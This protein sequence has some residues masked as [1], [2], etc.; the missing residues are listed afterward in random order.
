MKKM[1][2][3][4]L[5]AVW[6]AL[7]LVAPAW[8]AYGSFTPANQECLNCHGSSGTASTRWNF[9]PT[10]V[11]PTTACLQCHWNG[12]HVGA[13]QPRTDSAGN[14][15]G[16]FVRSDAYQLA[17]TD[18]TLFH[19]YHSG[20]NYWE[21]LLGS[22]SYCSSCHAAA[23]CDTC[24]ETPAGPTVRPHQNHAL[25]GRAAPT[26]TWAPGS[27]VMNFP[28]TATAGTLGCTVTE[29]HGNPNPVARVFSPGDVDTQDALTLEPVCTDCHSQ[30]VDHQAV[31][32]PSAQIGTDYAACAACHALNL[33]AEH[34]AN[35]GLQCATCH[36]PGAT[37]TN[38][39]DIGSVIAAFDGTDATKA[40][41]QACHGVNAGQH[42]AQHELVNPT[43]SDCTLCHSG[44]LVT[45]H[46]VNNPLGCDTC[47][48]AG[49][50][51][52]VKS[53]IATYGGANPLNPVCT[54]CH[55]SY[56][57]GATTKHTA[58]ESTGCT[59]CHL[60]LLPDEHARST[61]VSAPRSCA[62]CHPLPQSLIWTSRCAD[63]HKP[64]GLAPA[65]HL[66]IDTAHVSTQ[67][68]C[69]K[70]GCHASD[71]RTVHTAVG[72]NVCHSTTAVP[73]SADCTV[74]HGS[75]PH[76]MREPYKDSC[77]QCH[78]I[79]GPGAGLH[80]KHVIDKQVACVSCH[81]GVN[82]APPQ[83]PAC[84]TAACHEHSVD[85]VHA[86]K[87]HMAK[88]CTFCHK[89]GT[90]RHGPTPFKYGFTP[91]QFRQPCLSAGC[92][93][94]KAHMSNGE[95]LKCHGPDG[96]KDVH[97][98]QS[99][100]VV[101]RN[102][103]GKCHDL[104]QNTFTDCRLCHSF[105]PG[106]SSQYSTTTTTSST[107]TTTAPTTT[108]SST[109]TTTSSP[110]SSTTSTT[111]PA[112]TE[113]LVDKA[114]YL[115]SLNNNE[116]DNKA[117]R[118]SDVTLAMA[119]GGTAYSY[120]IERDRRMMSLQLNQSGGTVQKA[121]LKLYVNELKDG[122]SQTARIYLY[123]SDGNSLDGNLSFTLQRTG[124]VELDV[125]SLVRT[126]GGTWFKL[127]VTCSSEYFTISEA[128]FVL[129]R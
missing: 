9:S 41:C 127:R 31:H 49:A 46:T 10:P 20:D 2:F 73:T 21:N 88:P 55:A 72:C 7:L 38:G 65:A 22:S 99:K 5:A 102:A 43:V 86:K 42:T 3:V 74:C 100:H 95:C 128:G 40:G 24:H 47:H 29:C 8:A 129:T 80:D 121:V 116:P 44:N 77:D 59:T 33:A 109:T 84:A 6:V 89:S 96:V 52:T 103:C 26:L 107:T 108:T 93:D 92:H 91:E 110:T 106:W 119:D 30:A 61:S 94:Y 35:R 56:H 62:N 19:Q 83:P 112:V 78:S 39:T 75:G 113:Y 70:S 90:P 18:A 17:S 71:L 79:S 16:Y 68:G 34:V 48:G 1:L 104:T 69:A 51:A 45:E 36:A 32:D 105:S 122:K 101:D 54:D 13:S 27:S 123:K 126:A 14:F 50:P 66:A 111:V 25:G 12:P 11:Q 67:T 85:Q 118:T 28:V 115:E 82:P 57:A 23:A 15:I 63:C 98:V 97:L 120:R 125:A 4:S 76:T 114:V 60:L 81:S 117:G 53:V 37:S 64:G 124:W 87:E 58:S